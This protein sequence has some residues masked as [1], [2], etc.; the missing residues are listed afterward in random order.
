MASLPHNNGAIVPFQYQQNLVQ[1]QQNQNNQLQNN[2]YFRTYEAVT[3]AITTAK[4][5]FKVKNYYNYQQLTNGGI[6][7]EKIIKRST[8][9]GSHTRFRVFLKPV[10]LV[11]QNLNKINVRV[12]KSESSNNI[13][14]II[15]SNTRSQ[16]DT[17]VAKDIKSMRF[18][19]RRKQIILVSLDQDISSLQRQLRHDYR[20]QTQ[21]E[22][23]QV[24]TNFLQG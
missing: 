2:G 1:V 10:N 6:V 12:K 23:D 7:R 21:A 4:N 18:V 20:A 9:K 16:S 14:K 8:R 3:K 11:N 15:R 24:T 19:Q 22:R 17:H 13:Y 5:N